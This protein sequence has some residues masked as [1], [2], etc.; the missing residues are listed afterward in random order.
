MP[1]QPTSMDKDNPVW[2]REDIRRAAPALEVLPAAVL[3]RHDQAKQLVS[4][5][6]DPTVL[7]RFRATGDGGQSRINDALRRAARRLR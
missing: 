6:I 1:K 2:S 4:L 7:E 5:R 3:P